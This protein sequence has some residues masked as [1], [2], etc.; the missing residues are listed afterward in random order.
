MLVIVPTSFGSREMHSNRL[1]LW[2]VQID[3]NFDYATHEHMVRMNSMHSE[4]FLSSEFS[5]N[6]FD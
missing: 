6:D 4:P 1:L 2:T 5:S 3:L